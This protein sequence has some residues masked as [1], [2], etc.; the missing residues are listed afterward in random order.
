M[1]VTFE[2]LCKELATCAGGFTLWLGAGAPIALTNGTTPGWSKLV[3]DIRAAYQLPEAKASSR[4]R[5]RAL[6][7]DMPEQLEYLACQIRHAAFRKE[8]RARLIDPIE[9]A[10]LDYDTFVGAGDHRNT[11]E[12]DR[13]VQHRDVVSDAL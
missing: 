3:S 1:H 11:C 13:I 8:L 12:L 10:V 4:P 9:P 7:G 6:R 5:I 2:A